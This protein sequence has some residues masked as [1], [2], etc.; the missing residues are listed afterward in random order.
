MWQPSAPPAKPCVKELAHIRRV[1]STLM[2]IVPAWPMPQEL[3]KPS[4]VF[5]FLMQDSER[6][7]IGSVIFPE[8]HIA[9]F[10]VASDGALLGAFSNT[11]LDRD[12]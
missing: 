12:S 1:C 3:R 5:D 8:R 2:A 7:V 11:F 9:D 4:F 6:Q 10:G